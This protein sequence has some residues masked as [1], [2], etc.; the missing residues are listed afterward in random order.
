MP[1]TYSLYSLYSIY[2]LYSRHTSAYESHERHH[3]YQTDGI[4]LHKLHDSQYICIYAES[5]RRRCPAPPR[6]GLA[7]SYAYLG[8]FLTLKSVSD[9]CQSTNRWFRK[10]MCEIASFRK[11]ICERVGLPCFWQRRTDGF[12]SL[13]DYA[14][15]TIKYGNFGYKWTITCVLVVRNT[16]K[17]TTIC[18]VITISVVRI[19]VKYWVG[20]PAPH[21]SHYVKFLI[22]LSLS[23]A[24]LLASTRSLGLGLWRL[25]TVDCGV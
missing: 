22:K 3:A 20:P 7:G 17:G 23:F 2:S 25:G 16:K 12:S 6:G 8:W 11:T 9:P 15:N 5:V 18:T 1:P 14:Q 13:S 24:L 4:K 10:R 21:V 19:V